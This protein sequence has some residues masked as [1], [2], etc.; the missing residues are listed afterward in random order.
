MPKILK[1][2]FTGSGNKEMSNHL[3]RKTVLNLL[4][5]S[6]ILNKYIELSAA[7]FCASSR[8][9][10]FARHRFPSP[11]ACLSSELIHHTLLS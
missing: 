3:S 5:R 11:V 9:Q 8:H 2:N 6:K 10:W 4:L 1:C 7:L